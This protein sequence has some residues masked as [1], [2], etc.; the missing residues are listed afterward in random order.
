MS[1]KG[2]RSVPIALS[3]LEAGPG[4]RLLNLRQAAVYLGLSFWTLRDYTLQGLLPVVSLPPL[5]PR[6]GDRARQTLRRVLV[7]RADLDAFIERHK[8]A[9]DG[10]SRASVDGPKSRAKTTD[11][12]AVCPSCART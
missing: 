2:Q 11:I 8:D 4:P 10:Q 3:P 9:A 5:K 1:G 6:E 7:D 12:R